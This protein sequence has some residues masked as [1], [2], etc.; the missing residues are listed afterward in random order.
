M[1]R[2]RVNIGGETYD[3]EVE[4]A[5]VRPV[6]ARIDGETFLVDVETEA[7]ADRQPAPTAATPATTPCGRRLRNRRRAARTPFRRR[8]QAS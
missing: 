3:V 4:D 8:F 5:R 6:V 2:Y 1:K 7:A